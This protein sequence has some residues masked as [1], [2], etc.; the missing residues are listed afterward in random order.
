MKFQ[1]YLKNIEYKYKIS[2]RF[3]TDENI[4]VWYERENNVC[5]KAINY[6]LFGGFKNFS[7]GSIKMCAV[8]FVGDVKLLLVTR[9]WCTIRLR[10]GEGNGAHTRVRG[11]RG[12][13]ESVISFSGG[14]ERDVSPTVVPKYG[15]INKLLKLKSSVSL[16]PLASHVPLS[17]GI[18]DPH[19][20]HSA[21]PSTLAGTRTGV[22]SLHPWRRNARAR[23]SGIA[24]SWHPP[25]EP[26]KF[27]KKKRNYTLSTPSHLRSPVVTP[28][29]RPRYTPV[30]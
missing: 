20:F 7:T 30:W 19:K 9:A 21:R 4:I 24:S 11:G 5:N 28:A 14:G 26:E 18:K 1:V 2:V 23:A 16:L 29:K 12:E 3:N 6:H 17:A 27:R 8:R 22:G 13:R 15:E 25:F 10:I